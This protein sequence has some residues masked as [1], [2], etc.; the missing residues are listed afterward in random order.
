MIHYITSGPPHYS[1]RHMST[2]RPVGRPRKSAFFLP[3]PYTIRAIVCEVFGC[4]EDELRS[5]CRSKSLV[6]ARHLAMWFMRECIKMSYPEIGREFSNRDHTT[7]IHAFRKVE[8]ERITRPI[9][10]A[11]MAEVAERLLP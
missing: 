11:R 3:T 1:G 5:K 4:T 7:V 6:D 9:L 8:R 2:G 10:A